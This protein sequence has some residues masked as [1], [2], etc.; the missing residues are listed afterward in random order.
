MNV[1]EEKSNA[2]HECN[3]MPNDD[4]QCSQFCHAA[5]RVVKMVR[6]HNAEDEESWSPVGK[7]E[8]HGRDAAWTE[9]H[10][11]VEPEENHDGD[12]QPWQDGHGNG[13]R[14]E[15]IHGSAASAEKNFDGGGVPWCSKHDSKKPVKNHHGGRPHG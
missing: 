7:N 11:S 9:A 5:V 1:G 2:A 14:G 3:L 4:A 10:G 15:D 13:A 12:E 6:M 8:T